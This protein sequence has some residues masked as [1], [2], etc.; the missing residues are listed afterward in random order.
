MVCGDHFDTGSCVCDVLAEIAD[1]QQDVHGCLGSCS[2]SVRELIGGLAPTNFNTV[3][4]QLICNSQNSNTGA[5]GPPTVTG[6]FCGNV[7]IAQGFRRPTTGAGTTA[8]V[9]ATSTFFRVTS[10]DTDK[11]CAV[12]ELLCAPAD[13]PP[14]P[15]PADLTDACLETI[16]AATFT[17]TGICINVDL[18]CFCGVSCLPAVNAVPAG[19]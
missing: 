19:I 18:N 15:S 13:V 12:L 16:P 1:A 5:G 10:V 9:Y 8:L 6:G 17:R 2:E 3:P 14:G 11:C 4:V 7:F